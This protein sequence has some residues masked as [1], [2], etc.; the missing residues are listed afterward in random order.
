MR[1]AGETSPPAQQ[2]L[3]TDFQRQRFL[4]YGLRQEIEQRGGGGR[5]EKGIFLLRVRR[6]RLFQLPHERQGLTFRELR[7]YG[8]PGPLREAREP[9]KA[10]RRPER[11]GGMKNPF[12]FAGR[13]KTRACGL[14]AGW[15]LAAGALLALVPLAALAQ[16]APA[17]PP[18]ATSGAGGFWKSLFDNAFGLTLLFIFLCAVVAALIQARRRDRV[19]REFSGYHAQVVLQ[20]GRWIWGVMQ[21][22]PNGVLL[23]YRKPYRNEIGNTACSFILYQGEFGAIRAILRREEDQTPQN[24]AR[25]LHELE[26]YI[27]PTLPRRTWRWTL[28]Q[29]SVLRDALVKSIAL[30]IGQAK[31]IAPG[32]GWASKVLMTQDQR[33]TEL[34]GTVLGAVNLAHDPI[35]ESHFGR[36]V[37]IE[38][39]DGGVWREITGV[40]KDYSAEWL[41]ALDAG[42][43]RIVEAAIPPDGESVTSGEAGARLRREASELVIENLQ[44]KSIE[45]IEWITPEGPVSLG[46]RA[47][48]AHEVYRLEIPEAAR[49][50]GARLKARAFLLGDLI[51]PRASAL[52]RHSGP[53]EKDSWLQSLGL[54]RKGRSA[55]R[56]SNALP[57]SSEDTEI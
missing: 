22:F 26:R 6:G 35:L 38:V 37:V 47:I 14:R 54:R 56:G 20:D 46:D 23:R 27:N 7:R 11:Q 39:K 51:V 15:A 45:L 34:S 12:Y 52:V 8:A 33:L 57:E 43:P 53:V 1:G 17:P 49:G 13:I 2:R 44:P 28:K 42:W 32:T 41:L 48:A 24:R 10:G 30:I 19:L 50:A 29:F 55:R 4:Y 3:G 16:Q 31:R 25:R 9:R 18:A 36:P 40:L 5:G 21:V